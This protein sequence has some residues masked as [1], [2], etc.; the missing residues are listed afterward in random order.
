MQNQTCIRSWLAF[1]SILFYMAVVLIAG[2][3]L[4]FCS[5]RDYAPVA[6]SGHRTK[7]AQVDCKVQAKTG[8]G[9]VLET[10]CKW[11]AH[12][13]ILLASMLTCNNFD[14]HRY[15]TVSDQKICA[16]ATRAPPRGDSARSAQRLKIC[17]RVS[18]RPDGKT[19]TLNQA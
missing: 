7:T 1:V 10:E 8:C 5:L 9:T 14:T 16:R 13:Q 19:V 15:K 2:A 4:S 11:H 3:M 18:G 12:S 17:K 6:T